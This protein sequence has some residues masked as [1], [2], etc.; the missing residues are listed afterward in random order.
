MDDII[1]VTLSVPSFFL[2][3]NVDSILLSAHK[4]VCNKPKA[5]LYRLTSL[6]IEHSGCKY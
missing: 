1:Y 2:V 3:T 6:T 4:I 5:F